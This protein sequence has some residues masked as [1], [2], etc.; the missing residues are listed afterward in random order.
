MLNEL[1]III[2]LNLF[3]HFPPKRHTKNM[4]I[5]QTMFLDGSWKVVKTKGDF[6]D[7]ST[8][9][10]L[11]FGSPELL[12]EKKVV[13]DVMEKHAN[14]PVLFCST[15]GEI[16][17][18]EVFDDTVCLT[19]VEFEKTTCKKFYCSV[20][21]FKDSRSAGIKVYS[22]LNAPDLKLILVLTDGTMINGGE[23]VEG[24]NTNNMAKIP[25]TGG[26]AADD[27]KFETAWVGLNEAPSPGKII[28]LGFY[29][30]AISVGHGS[31]GGWD[32]FGP[33]R[34]V[35]KAENN[36]LYEI[37]G[38]K[39]FELYKTYL[40]EYSDH[41]PGSGLL[42]PLSIT[43]PN[44]ERSVV[45]TMLGFNEDDQSL[46][47]AGNVLEGS[48]L[49]LM[50]ANFDQLIDGSAVAAKQSVSNAGET[51]YELALLISC[52]GR[53]LLLR[54]WV[55]DEVIEAAATLGEMHIAGFYSYS[56]IAPFEFRSECALHNQTMTITT[57]GEKI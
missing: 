46:T 9:F 57:I 53:K 48:K 38:K 44:G 32:E 25:I 49:R 22:Q 19:A 52:A 23:F 30:D 14:C 56:E 2:G 51:P 41:L 21:D 45:R 26:L 20:D 31:F 16:M 54:E 27:K 18:D 3:L 28:A 6:D 1:I 13:A 7:E 50:K 11:A 55:Q 15:A 24:L 12:A 8:S 35:T 17:G 40:G 42:F 34:T 5:K 4:K 10:V 36:I 43:P 37:D 39:A 47:L 33:Q 29:G